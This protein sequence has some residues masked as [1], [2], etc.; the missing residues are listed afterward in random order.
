MVPEN[1]G[2]LCY[3]IALA[4]IINGRP[5]VLVHGEHERYI[6]GAHAWI[7]RDGNIIWDPISNRSMPADDRYKAEARY[8][9]VEAIDMAIKHKHCGPWHKSIAVANNGA[10]I[11]LH[12]VLSS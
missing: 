4:E 10:A 11:V 7:E 6:N 3:V 12:I 1:R 9:R 8:S 2:G 5:G